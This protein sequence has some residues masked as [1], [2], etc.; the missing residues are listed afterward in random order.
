MTKRARPEDTG[1]P[2][3]VAGAGEQPPAAATAG[4]AAAQ[5]PAQPAAAAAAQAQ[6]PTAQATTVEEVQVD[7]EHPDLSG[8][9][10]PTSNEPAPATV[11]DPAA[12]DHAVSDAAEP[13]LLQQLDAEAL[14]IVQFETQR[15]VN[16]LGVYRLRAKGPTLYALVQQRPMPNG[17]SIP[18]R[19]HE[20][21]IAYLTTQDVLSILADARDLSLRVGVGNGPADGARTLGDATP[22]DAKI[23]HGDPGAILGDAGGPVPTPTQRS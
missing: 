1:L 16:D 7:P 8:V 19:D 21:V 11:N 9:A 17:L 5:D 4:A 2:A 15:R 18:E 23:V 6:A 20:P 10:G 13:S 12:T 3:G 22:P 14:Q